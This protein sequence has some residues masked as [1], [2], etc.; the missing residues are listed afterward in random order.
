MSASRFGARESTCIAI[1]ALGLG[2]GGA[3]SIAPAPAEPIS[4]A[5]GRHPIADG[6]KAA[7]PKGGSS[8]GI[9]CEDAQA[10]NVD[11]I[12]MQGGGQADLT[13]KDFSAVLN[14][15][16]YLAPCEVPETSKIQI[17]V[18]IR[19]GA[20]IGVTVTLDPSNPDLEIC[21][22]KQVRVLA[23]ASHPKMDIVRVQF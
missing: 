9:T 23:F 17:C 12:D 6:T 22:A 13:A 19:S 1:F 7:S 20:A 14:N 2:C 4:H 21:V 3:G 11:E 8:D 15:G 16:T 10:Q 5:A 18:A